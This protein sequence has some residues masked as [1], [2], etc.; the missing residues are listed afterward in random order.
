[1]NLGNP[2][3]TVLHYLIIEETIYIGY[4]NEFFMMSA[5][6]CMVIH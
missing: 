4:R 2:V 6:V 5:L 1:M 3:E